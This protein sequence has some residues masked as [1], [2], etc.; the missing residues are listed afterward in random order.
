MVVTNDQHATLGKDPWFYSPILA[1]E[2]SQDPPRK[3]LTIDDVAH[4]LYGVSFQLARL[5]VHLSETSW[6]RR[7]R[8]F[9]QH[10]SALALVLYENGFRPEHIPALLEYAETYRC[11]NGIRHMN[12][13]R[14]GIQKH[15]QLIADEIN[16]LSKGSRF[17]PTNPNQP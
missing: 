2:P 1:R 17:Q 7:N 12:A 15:Y 8:E 5:N 9:V 16:T 11:T 10:L 14:R 13:L 4:N 6:V 3:P